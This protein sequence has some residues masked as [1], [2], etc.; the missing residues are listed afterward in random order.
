MN[1]ELSKRLCQHIGIRRKYRIEGI[2]ALYSEEKYNELLELRLKKGLLPPFCRTVL[3]DF[4]IPEN[5]VK[6]L[7]LKH[8]YSRY[9]IDG[10]DFTESAP[11]ITQA[12]LKIIRD[13]EQYLMNEV[14]FI[15]SVCEY[16]DWI[17]EK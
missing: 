12:L 8:K 15:S 7:E 13:C 3:P 6:L 11:F 14:G 10:S 17:Y 16:E 1:K 4:S 2:N 9:K 5:F